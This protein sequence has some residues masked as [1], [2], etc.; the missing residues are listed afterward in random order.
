MSVSIK[1][2]YSSMTHI[3]SNLICVLWKWV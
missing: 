2:I 3:N 1:V